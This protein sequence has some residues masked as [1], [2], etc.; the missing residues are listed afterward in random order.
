MKKI[1]SPVLTASLIILVYACGADK[2]KHCNNATPDY[3]YYSAVDEDAESDYT[4]RD[5]IPE[6]TYVPEGGYVSNADIAVKIAE[7]IWLPIY[8]KG[9]YDEKPYAVSLVNDS[10][11]VVKGSFPMRRNGNL[12]MGGT[13]YIEIQKKDGKILKVIHEK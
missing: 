8:G 12:V 10:I 7:V 6:E 9:I 5:Y 4:V 2:A 11:W 13:A 3:Y 1:T